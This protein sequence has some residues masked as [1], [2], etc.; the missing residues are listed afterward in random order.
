[1]SDVKKGGYGDADPRWFDDAIRSYLKQIQGFGLLSPEEELELARKLK[2]STLTTDERKMLTHKFVNANLR[3]VI[4]VAKKY[5]A[6]GMSFLDLI[7]EGNVGLMKAV[8]R[9]DYTLGYK[10]STYATYWIKQA[11]TRALDSHSRT[12]RVPPDVRRVASRVKS[13]Q[14][15]IEQKTGRM[16]TEEEI[17]AEVSLSVDE[18]QSLLL[19]GQGIVSLDQPVGE[20]RDHS[21]GDFVP[22][23]S[24]DGVDHETTIKMLQ[25]RMNTV[26][27]ELPYRERE[28]IKL[29]YGLDDGYTYTLEEVGMI[30]K[31]TRERIRQMEAN[32]LEKLQHPLRNAKLQ[33]FVDRRNEE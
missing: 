14:R 19:V 10:F 25:E 8:E 23:K 11:I 17:A 13:A 4:S 16:P 32:A 21:L 31:L 22:D 30:F 2:D 5:R 20:E 29:R 12:V 18:V 28:I 26:L 6:F 33:G 9:Y 15:Q 3:L 27:A 24:E 1:M 7:Q